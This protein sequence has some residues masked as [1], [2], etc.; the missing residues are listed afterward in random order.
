[1]DFKD[2]NAIIGFAIEKEQDAARFYED[3]A[4]EEPFSS[5]KE[6][7][8]EFAAE[9]HKHEALLADLQA[10]NIGGRLDHYDYHWIADIKRS[11][12]VD[13]TEYRPGMAYHEL[14]MLAMKREE[15]SLKLYNEMLAHAQDDAQEKVF[16]ML[17]Q[18]E[19]KHKLALETMYDDYMAEIGD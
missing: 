10:G 4:K 13:A 15:A 18:E 6:M 14:L 17:C 5:K 1:M 16:K 7:L 9:E 12:Y 11:D 8:L 19:A 3:A 2:L